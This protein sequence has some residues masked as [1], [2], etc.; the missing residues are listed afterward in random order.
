MPVTNETRITENY[1]RLEL[2]VMMLIQ[3]HHSK[4]DI[5]YYSH[6][7]GLSHRVYARGHSAEE[8]Y[9][10][11]IKM[12]DKQAISSAITLGLVHF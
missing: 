2:A 5:P 3:T 1:S 12:V 10:K 6:V 4:H 7:S 8:A 9:N 11:A